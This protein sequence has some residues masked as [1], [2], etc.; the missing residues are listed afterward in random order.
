MAKFQQLHDLYRFP[1]FRPLDRIRGSGTCP[2]RSLTRRRDRSDPGR[3]GRKAISVPGDIRDEGFYR[4]LVE[5]AIKA[6]GG[7]DILVN[8]AGRR[9]AL[10][11]EAYITTE[12][13][14]ATS[15]KT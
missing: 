15:K 6:L 13:F 5:S 1:G 9:L 7:L 4:N 3:G 10:Q 12:Q 8:N 2:P 14:D 11:S